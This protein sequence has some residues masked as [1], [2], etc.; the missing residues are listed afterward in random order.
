MSPPSLGARYGAVPFWKIGSETSAWSS[1]NAGSAAPHARVPVASGHGDG[2]VA[3][4]TQFVAAGTGAAATAVARRCAG[5]AVCATVKTVA[6]TMVARSIA[7]AAAHA[8]KGAYAAY[9]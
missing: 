9:P 6:F 1:S 5:F 4:F 3:Q 2:V 8:R 7:F